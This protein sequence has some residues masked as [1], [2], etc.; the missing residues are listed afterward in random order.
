MKK[1]MTYSL[2]EAL[3]LSPEWGAILETE[4][5]WVRVV[6]KLNWR[7]SVRIGGHVLHTVCE[8]RQACMEH[9]RLHAYPIDEG[10]LP[11]QAGSTEAVPISA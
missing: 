4:S 5:V 3:D 7:V 1:P 10:W 9:L 11:A 8:T 2:N 6:P